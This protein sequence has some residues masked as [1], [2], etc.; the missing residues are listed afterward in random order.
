MEDVHGNTWLIINGK[1]QEK[2]L[3]HKL[4]PYQKTQ[5]KLSGFLLS[6]DHDAVSLDAHT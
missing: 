2:S 3:G 1:G 5:R 6:S 4:R